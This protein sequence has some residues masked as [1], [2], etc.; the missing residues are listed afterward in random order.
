MIREGIKIIDHVHG[1][2][3]PINNKFVDLFLIRVIELK[4]R[5]T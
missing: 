1:I 4:T 3:H 5:S 2:L